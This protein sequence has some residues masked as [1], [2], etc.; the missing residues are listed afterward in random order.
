MLK[1]SLQPETRSDNNARFHAKAHSRLQFLG[2]NFNKTKTLIFNF[3]C[4]QSTNVLIFGWT[5]GNIVTHSFRLQTYLALTR[6]EIQSTRKCHIRVLWPWAL[7][8]KVSIFVKDYLFQGYR[9]EVLVMGMAPTPP[10][11]AWRTCPY[12]QSSLRSWAP[13]HTIV[14]L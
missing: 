11:F 14:V 5:L 1:K 6:L 10:Q 7:W 8:E 2:Y 3:P 12:L 4:S 9:I 13:L